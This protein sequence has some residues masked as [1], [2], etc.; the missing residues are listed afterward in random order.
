[1]SGGNT[2]RQ[3]CCRAA[4]RQFSLA[5]QKT[6][7]ACSKAQKADGRESRLYQP[8]PGRGSSLPRGGPHG[9]G[10]F[11]GTSVQSGG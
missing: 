3:L 5:G 10:A 11:T 1:M 4:C 9:P 7:D 8:D 6:G 2:G